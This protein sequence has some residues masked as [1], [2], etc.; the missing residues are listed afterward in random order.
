MVIVSSIHKKKWIRNVL[1]SAE[2]DS[3]VGT[4]GD[5]EAE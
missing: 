3:G 1:T 2:E 5:L 4:W